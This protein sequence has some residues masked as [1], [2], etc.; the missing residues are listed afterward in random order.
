MGLDDAMDVRITA[1]LLNDLKAVKPILFPTLWNVS[2][3]FRLH[4]ESTSV[5]RV[6]F[7]QNTNAILYRRTM[8]EHMLPL[9]SSNSAASFVSAIESATTMSKGRTECSK[10]WACPSALGTPCRIE[11]QGNVLDAAVTSSTI[12]D[13]DTVYRFVTYFSTGD[14]SGNRTNEHE[15]EIKYAATMSQGM[16]FRLNGHIIK[17]VATPSHAM[18]PIVVSAS[19]FNVQEGWNKLEI[20]GSDSCCGVSRKEKL[21]ILII[22][23]VLIVLAQLF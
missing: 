8:E 4:Q 19:D 20:F 18:V 3:G 5:H 7:N 17:E 12:T 21:N 16:V 1:P 23:I 15:W 13:H 11:I 22:C 9:L 2:Y 10:E 14:P 6:R